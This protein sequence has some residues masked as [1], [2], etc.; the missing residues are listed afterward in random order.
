MTFLP[1]LL[2]C[3]LFFN[4]ILLKCQEKNFRNKKK[5][6]ERQAEGLLLPK[7]GFYDNK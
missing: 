1:L 7:G 5:V 4:H 6:D 2:G 3:C